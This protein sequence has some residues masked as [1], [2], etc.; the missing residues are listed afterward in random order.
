MLEIVNKGSQGHGA[1]WHEVWKGSEEVQTVQEELNRM[2][3]EK[4]K[5]QPSE[6]VEEA[7][8]HDEFAMPFLSQLWIV[9]QRVF[10]QYWRMP[11]YILAKLML[12]V[13]SGLFIGFSFFNSDS[14]TQGLQNVLFSVFM[15]TA[16]FSSLVQQVDSQIFPSFLSTQAYSQ[17]DYSSL[18]DATLPL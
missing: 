17:T 15:I 16:I 18:C 14:S 4:L 3:D 6:E 10:Q 12:G 1:D 11:E 2:H 7:G 8:S 9:T 5:T 13:T